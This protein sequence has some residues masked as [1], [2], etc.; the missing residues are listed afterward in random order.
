MELFRLLG[1]IVLNTGKTEETIDDI[2]DK[3]GKLGT[4]MESAG[5]KIASVGTKLTKTFTVGATAATAA[6][7]AFAS[8]V[9]STTDHID[10]MSQKI[11]ISRTA[12]QELD[13]VCSQS[14]TS[15]D[16]LQAGMKTLTNQMQSASEGGSTAT[17]AFDALG[18]SIYDSSGKL[19]DQETMMW[20]AMTALQ[21]ME[22]QTEKSA[23]ATDLFGRSGSELMPMLN[24]AAGSIEAMRKQAHD[25]GLVLSDEAVNAGVTYTDTIDQLKRAM[26]AAATAAG[27][28][29]LPI[30]TQFAQWL[31][32]TGVPAIQRLSEKVQNALNWFNGL[33]D[34]AK[35]MIAILAGVV[36]AIGPV[37]TIV[38]K[39]ISSF[40][41]VVSVG[42]KII[43]VITGMNP[44]MLAIVGAI[45][46][47]VAIGVTLYKNW[48]TIKE[49]AGEV[50]DGVVAKFNNAKEKM[51][52]IIDTIK[53]F[54]DFKF[55]LPHIPTP[56]FTIQP[57]GWELGDLLKGVKPSLGIE[58]YAKAMDNPMVM[59]SPTIFG[60]NPRTGNVMGGGEAG[61]EVVSGTNTL[62]GMISEAVAKSN[63]G[64][65]DVLYKILSAIVSMDG[66]MGESMKKALDGTGLNVNKREFGRLVREVV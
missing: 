34:G 53:G 26:G 44:V 25:L 46:A 33:S 52:K 55:K 41:T 2:N 50:W 35:T 51:K 62:M 66:N 38:G 39:M 21:G 22:N 4:K 19:K 32:S 1:T 37:L 20:E 40:S 54:F 23:I 28:A 27:T 58:W 64:M 9:A 12:Y 7:V 59:T 63:G 48:D 10:K 31:I 18:L 29:L 5:Q 15:V 13:F 36:V 61:S 56:R 57:S 3:A 43:T 60:Y 8:K 49:K 14:G 24:G 16:T 6:T 11:G 17:A 30:L 45:A 47:V 42:S 65:V